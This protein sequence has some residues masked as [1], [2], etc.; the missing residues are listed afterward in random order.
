MGMAGLV[1]GD[2]LPRDLYAGIAN[3][4]AAA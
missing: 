3:R 1:G 4:V 2:T